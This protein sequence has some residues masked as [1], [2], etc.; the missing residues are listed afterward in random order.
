MKRLCFCVAFIWLL[1][2]ATPPQASYMVISGSTA[3]GDGFVGTL[4]E[5][6]NQWIIPTTEAWFTRRTV[7]AGN[8]GNVRYGHIYMGTSSGTDTVALSLQQD[9]DG[10]TVYLYGSADHSGGMGWLNIDMGS[11]YQITEST[12]YRLI[13]QTQETQT[14]VNIINDSA[15]TRY[16]GSWTYNPSAA[17]TDD[18][19]KTSWGLV[20]CFD[21][22][23]GD[24]S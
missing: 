5:N 15:G 19:S 14:E 20:L 8:G 9:T 7:S 6:D 12:V 17:V 3:V 1:F 24:P 22:Q 23:P 16:D 11:T 10:G 18:G 4:T 21:N 13:V 2:F